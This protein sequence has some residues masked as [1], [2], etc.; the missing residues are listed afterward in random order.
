[1]SHST[2]PIV[3][4]FA[5]NDPTGGA[6]LGADI[7]TLAALGCHAAPIITCVTVQN[8]HNVLHNTALPAHQVQAQAQA[9]LAEMSL[10]AVK[11]GLLGSVEIIEVIQQLLVAYPQ[12]PLILDPIL[13]AGGGR[14][15]AHAAIQEAMIQYLLPLT[16]LITPNCQEALQLTRTSTIAAAAM[17]FMQWGCQFVCI[18]GTEAQT[19][20]VV[21]HLYGHQQQLKSWQWPRLPHCYHGSGCTFAASVAAF[22]AR[23][24]GIERAVE[25]AQSYTWRCL[26]TGYQPGTGQWFPNR[27]NME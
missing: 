19:P 14:A 24:Q 17:Q 7:Q 5:G 8:S 9:I 2:P 22:V 26:Q 27:L 3:L 18:T 25:A 6:G 20:D 11:I 15:L 4:V 10:A 1:M 23:G 21:H 12:L 13:A 16:D